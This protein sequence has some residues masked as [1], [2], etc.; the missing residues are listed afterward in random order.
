MAITSMTMFTWEYYT[1]VIAN[2]IQTSLELRPPNIDPY[3][4]WLL[5]DS[6]FAWSELNIT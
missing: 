2:Y 5:T 4:K 3:G 1:M 6:E